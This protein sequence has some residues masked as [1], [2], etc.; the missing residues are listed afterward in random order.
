[1][2]VSFLSEYVYALL[3]AKGEDKKLH[4]PVEHY[5]LGYSDNGFLRLIEG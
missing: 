4:A 3:Q 5:P 2:Q 1:M